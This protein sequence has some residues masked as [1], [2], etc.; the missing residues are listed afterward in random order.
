MIIIK[1]LN[2]KGLEGYIQSDEFRMAKHIAISKHRAISHLTNPKAHDDD[3]LL[4]L[5]YEEDVMVGYLGILP[6][7]LVSSSGQHIHVGWM[8][9]LWIDPIHRGKK[10]ASQLVSACLSSWNH[11]II[12]TEYTPEAGKL[13]RKSKLFDEVRISIGRR[14]YLQSNLTRLLPPKSKRW[15][16]VSPVLVIVDATVNTLIK[17]I[18]IFETHK[19]FPYIISDIDFTDDEMAIQ[20]ENNKHKSLFTRTWTDFDWMLKYPWILQGNDHSSD[21][22]RYHF[23]SFERFFIFKACSLKDEDGLLLVLIIFSIRNGHL[24]IPYLFHDNQDRVVRDLISHLIHQY[25]V[26]MF[27]TYHADLLQIFQSH[28]LGR[29]F[30]K[31]VKRSYMASKEIAHHFSDHGLLIEDGDG[32]CAFT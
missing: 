24:R 13:Y 8:S 25:D 20:F 16:A 14:W 9:C 23:S 6:D 27:T 12:L 17:G 21:A 3:I 11:H 15:S 7:D 10:I 29:Y 28:T 22:Q 19:P 32:D 5:A 30:S 26:L 18:K 2:S 1:Y 31:S 4:I